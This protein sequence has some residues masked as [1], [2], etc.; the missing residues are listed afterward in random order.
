LVAWDDPG[1]DWSSFGRVV[2][3][4]TWDSVDRPDDYLRW[5]KRVS[6]VSVLVNPA[7][8]V[9][10]D[11]DKIHQR[12]MADRG[13]PLVPTTWVSPGDEWVPPAAEFIVKPSI[14]AGGRSTARYA[15]A[16]M[17]QAH[18]HVQAL[19]RAG[20]TALVQEYQHS[21]ETVGEVNLI[22]VGGAFSH[23]VR[24]KAVLQLGEGVVERPWERM[25]WSGVTEPDPGQLAA[26]GTAMAYVHDRFGLAPTYARVDLV[27]DRAGTPLVLEIELIDPLL[28]LELVPEAASG[29]ADAALNV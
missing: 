22:F 7:A 8:M 27:A 24:K 18:G 12:D 1:V 5:V 13:V 20:L 28:S 15:N 4:S 3:S 23:A 6:A 21:V 14:S 11:L 29:L 17:A 25:A 2:L 19:H 9:A 26:A 16:H 10:W